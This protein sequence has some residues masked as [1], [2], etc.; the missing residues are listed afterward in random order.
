VAIRTAELGPI[1]P[2]AR[3]GGILVADSSY[4]L[5]FSND[6]RVDGVVWPA[7]Y[8]ARRESGVVLLIDPAGQVIAHE[9]DHVVAGGA[10][11]ADG[12]SRPCFNIRV[13]PPSRE[14]DGGAWLHAEEWFEVAR[15]AG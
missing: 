14:I 13:E 11:D 12:L 5:A 7:G 3:I 9:G 15:R 4:G 2:S 10:A 6:G 8:T 1:C